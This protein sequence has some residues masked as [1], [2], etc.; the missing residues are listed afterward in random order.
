MK[1]SP[2]AEMLWPVLPQRPEQVGEQAR[3]QVLLLP[4]NGLSVGLILQ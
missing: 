4:T 2:K 1:T 3:E